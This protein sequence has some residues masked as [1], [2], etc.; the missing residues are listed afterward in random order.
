MDTTGDT[1]SAISLALG[2]A[3]ASGLNLY[4]TVLI[5]GAFGATGL[6][7]LPPDLQVLATPP[8]LFAAAALYAL[9]FLADKVPGIDSLN[10]AVHTFIRIPAGALL[11]AGSMS[12]MDEPWQMVAALVL[13]G[14]VTAGTH[15]AKTGTRAI[16]NT[17]PEPFSNWFA[18][19]FEDVIVAVG[20][21][22]ALFQPT[23]FL[24][25]MAA[26]ALLLIWLLP[27][28][29]RGLKAIW[30]RLQGFQDARRTEGAGRALARAFTGTPAERPAQ[31]PAPRP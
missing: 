1:L 14:M 19:V 21:L 2:A 13:G 26:F 20:L 6:V 22:L 15:A 31:P 10:D 29:W 12:G 27:K 5:I 7:D 24:I 17:S 30:A 18:S 23:L 4:A 8:V 11:A 25:W 3:W 16:I 9:E 28:L